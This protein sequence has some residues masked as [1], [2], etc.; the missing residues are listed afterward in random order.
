MVE[1]FEFGLLLLS[2]I[3]ANLIEQTK[4]ERPTRLTKP[5]TV[6]QCLFPQASTNYWYV[7]HCKQGRQTPTPPCKSLKDNRGRYERSEVDGVCLRR[8]RGR[9]V[10]RDNRQ[11]LKLCPVFTD[12]K[13][14]T[15]RRPPGLAP[16]WDVSVDTTRLWYLTPL[17]RLP[18]LTAVDG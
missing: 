12:D 2:Y 17:V 16:L 1:E 4:Q 14:F 7:S 8:G 3:V 10:N 11:V 15:M 9:G 18:T 5:T 6:W 13:R